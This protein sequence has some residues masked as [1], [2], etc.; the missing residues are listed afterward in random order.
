MSVLE[1]HKEVF[2]DDWLRK[3]LEGIIKARTDAKHNLMKKK[4]QR[5]IHDALELAI[6]TARECGFSRRLS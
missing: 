4:V 1:I 2:E 3:E 5:V 6:I